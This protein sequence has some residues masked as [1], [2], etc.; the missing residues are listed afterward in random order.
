M[1][2]PGTVI[3]AETLERGASKT[4]FQGIFATGGVTLS[5]IALMTGL[6]NHTVQNWVKRGYVSSPK[7]R[8]YSK[9]QFARIVIIN[10]LKECLSLEN[11]C[12]LIGHINGALDDESDDRIGDSELYHRYVD[13]IISVGKTFA[14]SSEIK[15]A[16]MNACTDYSV[17][18]ADTQGRLCDVLYIM[19]FSHYCAEAKKE[20]HRALTR[21]QSK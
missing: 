12:T 21:I 1:N 15:A 6:E 9:D 11:I 7:G 2:F 19:A 16:A 17:G 13:M 14:D 18:D 10:M 8:V 20:A 3:E 4:L 5:Q